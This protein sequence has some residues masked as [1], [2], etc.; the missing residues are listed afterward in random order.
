[1]TRSA[2]QMN[3]TMTAGIQSVFQKALALH[4]RGEFAL[5]QALYSQVLQ[6]DPRHFDSLHLLGLTHVQEG[7]PDLGVD[8][9][10]RAIGLRADVPEAHYNLG[11]A[12][13]SL[14]RPAEAL[15]H[16]D[17]AI[18]LDGRDPQY[19]F[20]RGNALK[21]L[22]RSDEALAEF[23][24][25]LRLAPRYAEAHNNAG[26]LL[27]D[28][29]R[30]EEALAR[31][32]SAI[33]L[34]P[35]YAEAYSNRGNVLKD[36]RR[37]LDAVASHDQALRLRPRYAEACSNRGNA[38]AQL[39]RF[40]EAL[41]GH[42]KA[43]ALKPGYAEAH[44][45]RGNALKELGRL[46]EALAAYERAIALRPGYAEAYSNRGNVLKDMKR[47]DEAMASHDKAIA[48]QPGYA[49]AYNNRGNL[50]K[51]LDRID[52]AYESYATAAR[53]QP[54]HVM[55]RYNMSLLDLQRR[56]LGKGFDLYRLR[57]QADRHDSGPQTSIPAWDGS[58]IDGEVLLWAEQGI[59]DEVFFASMLSLIDRSR[60]RLALS[61]DPRLHPIFA[62]SFPGI[63]LLDRASTRSAVAG[64]FAAQAPVGDLGHILGVDTRA[65]ARRR[66]PYLLADAARTARLREATRVPEGNIVCGLSWRS[67][68]PKAGGDRSI[69]LSD[70]AA[71]LR[72]PGVSFVNLQYGDVAAEIS[73]ARELTGADIRSVPEVDVFSDID[74]LMS[75]MSLCDTVI[76]ID[77]LTA[78]LAGAIGKASSVLVPI[79]GGQH[80][81]WGG[82]SPSLW[83]PS[84]TLLYQQAIG[85]WTAPI[86]GAA[87]R[88][89]DLR[90]GVRA[91]ST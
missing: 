33:R 17:A 42:D 67:G 84:L 25:A 81:Y 79:G 43:I 16:F 18:R 64:D 49:E 36:L 31:Y 22:G 60:M 45:N 89:Q 13:L 46:E 14:Q 4:Q 15:V 63:R 51:D 70:L 11:N 20:E 71:V 88:L 61:A 30:L 6:S 90:S 72:I 10:Q 52:E 23:D 54:S 59:G 56:A 35:D 47:L 21:E 24:E 34:K 38:L 29:G 26:I 78:H 2:W 68:N 76:T 77:N 73:A 3:T 37:P 19:H 74:G 32:D 82:E 91:A 28:A 86:Q 40:E 5:A 80:W 75:L 55:A 87:A 62:R 58:P 39:R 65:V 9:I 41:A 1:M 44:N 66:Y 27:K 12:L 7:R 8:Y 50:L 85:D 69:S 48:L 53:L 57:W 83:Y